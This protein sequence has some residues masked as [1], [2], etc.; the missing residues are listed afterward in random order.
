VQLPLARA[1]L[2][3]IEVGAD[4]TGGDPGERDS[5]Q[6]VPVQE[7]LDGPTVGGSGVR[8]ADARVEEFVPGKAGGGHAVGNEGGQGGASVD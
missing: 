8:I 3:L 5:F 2:E 6:L 4:H 7:P 1:A